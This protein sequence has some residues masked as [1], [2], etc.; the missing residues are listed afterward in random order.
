MT[1]LRSFLLIS[2]YAGASVPHLA[3]IPACLTDFNTP[4]GQTAVANASWT[5]VNVPAST[6]TTLHVTTT[7]GSTVATVTG[8]GPSLM[9]TTIT[10]PNIPP[11]T[12]VITTT[13]GSTVWLSSPAT[14]TGSGL[15]TFT[16]PAYAMNYPPAEAG[17]TNCLVCPAEFTTPMCAGQYFDYYMCAGHAYTISMCG[18]TDN[19]NSYLDVTTVAGTA[20]ASGFDPTDDDGCGTAGGHASLVF[21]PTAA[22]TYRVRLWLNPCS[23]DAAMCGTMTVTCNTIPIGMAEQ[24]TNALELIVLPN[25]AQDRLELRSAQLRGAAITISDLSG[26][27]VLHKT[28][29]Q[30]DR[31]VLDSSE[32]TSGTYVVVLRDAEGRRTA[33]LF[34]KE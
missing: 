14:T 17:C 11:G 9:C 5:A 21:T 13:S 2:A 31:E 16:L 12:T 24:A 19:W 25:P 20:L 26:R 34:V 29:L 10:G 6:S 23:V 1:A 30:N 27:V 32:W 4:P 28:A 33:R 8:G 3:Q 15:H 22:D 7:A 18:S